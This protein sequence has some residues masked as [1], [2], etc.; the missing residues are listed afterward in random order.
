[1]AK[2]VAILKGD[3]AAEEC[4][5]LNLCTGLSSGT[6]GSI[7]AMLK[8][9]ASPHQEALLQ[10]SILLEMGF[11]DEEAQDLEMNLEEVQK[12]ITERLLDY[13]DDL[14]RKEGYDENDPEAMLLIDA[15]NAFNELSRF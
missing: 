13:E 14:N 7:H 15:R 8:F 1:M 11:T 6:K 4:G 2:T 5:N 3:S 10:K 9:L 12:E